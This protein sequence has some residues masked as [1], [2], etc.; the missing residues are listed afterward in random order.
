M[1]GRWG[2]VHLLLERVENACEPAARAPDVTLQKI[3]RRKIERVA[4]LE[5][6][7]GQA[8]VSMSMGPN[9]G[10]Q[11]AGDVAREKETL[12]QLLAKVNALAAREAA[13]KVIQGCEDG[14]IKPLEFRAP[15]S[16]P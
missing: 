3:L 5:D 7:K 10:H 4:E 2:L 13:K 14:K 1:A 15:S 6:P 16:R 11:F 12:Q 8:M 9:I